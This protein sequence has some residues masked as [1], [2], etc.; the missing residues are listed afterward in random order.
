MV[1]HVNPFDTGFDE[2]SHVMRFAAIAREVQTTAANPIV[3]AIRQAMIRVP[4]PVI[5]RTSTTKTGMPRIVE[6]D[7]EVIEGEIFCCPNCAILEA[8]G[9]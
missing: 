6:E 3:R 5:E 4:V 8:Y 2:N 1:V 7:F 9:F